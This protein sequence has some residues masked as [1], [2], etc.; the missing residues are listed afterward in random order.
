MHFLRNYLLKTGSTITQE[1]YSKLFQILK[2]SEFFKLITWTV[3]NYFP[4]TSMV[5]CI[6]R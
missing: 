2:K 5:R 4:K 6:N 3:A 1:K